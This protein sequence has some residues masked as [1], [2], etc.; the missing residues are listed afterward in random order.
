MLEVKTP[1]K[2]KHDMFAQ[3][4]EIQKDSLSGSRNEGPTSERRQPG[5][6]ILFMPH[7]LDLDQVSVGNKQCLLPSFN[8]STY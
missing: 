7:E 3:C 4:N 5:C 6:N 2:C 8:I 1:E